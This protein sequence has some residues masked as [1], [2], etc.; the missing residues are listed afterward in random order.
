MTVRPGLE[1]A[2]LDS[3][4]ILVPVWRMRSGRGPACRRSGSEVNGEFARSSGDE[5]CRY[6]D[7]LRRRVVAVD[8]SEQ[9]SR[10][11]DAD[12]VD[13]LGDDGHRGLTL[14]G[15]P[16]SICERFDARFGQG[17]RVEPRTPRVPPHQRSVR[18]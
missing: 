6:D 13:V 8:A 15:F 1:Q 16:P 18:G 12:V 17:A 9:Q 3:R 2:G 5:L 11:L 4:E 7:P 10:G 14:P